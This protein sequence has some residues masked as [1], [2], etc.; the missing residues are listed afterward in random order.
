[1]L[2]SMVQPLPSL[3]DGVLQ[4]GMNVSVRFHHPGVRL[5]VDDCMESSFVSSRSNDPAQL[6][7]L[8]R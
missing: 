1:M 5:M 6:P 3:S 4:L 2:V 8:V 7:K